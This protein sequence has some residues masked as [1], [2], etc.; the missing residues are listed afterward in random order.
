[1][2]GQPSRLAVLARI[3]CSP[4]N[5]LQAHQQL[6]IGAI[7]VLT[8][9]SSPSLPR[10][11]HN[12]SLAPRMSC[13][14]RGDRRDSGTGENE[15]SFVALEATLFAVHGETV[16]LLIAATVV[17]STALRIIPLDLEGGHVKLRVLG[18]F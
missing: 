18:G 17:A 15:A 12:G 11:R 13:G 1:L 2:W 6:G 4:S 7:E 5:T 9:V 16:C 8:G 3:A 14:K 10:H